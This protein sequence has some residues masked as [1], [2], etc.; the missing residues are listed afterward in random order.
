MADKRPFPPEEFSLSPPTKRPKKKVACQR[1]HSQ[2]IKCTGEQPCAKCVQS[3]VGNDCQYQARDRKITVSQSYI[4]Q[5][6]AENERLRDRPGTPT[7]DAPSDIEP[8]RVEDHAD[9]DQSRRNP[10]IGDQAWFQSYDPVAPPIYVGEAACTAFATR[11]RRFL[12]GNTTAAHIPRTQYMSE[13][14]LSALSNLDVPWPSFTHASLLLKVAFHQA[15]RVYHMMCRK[16][17]FDTLKETYETQNF[18][19][20]VNK[21]KFFTLFALGEV[22]S[23]RSNSSTGQVPGVNY[24][25]KSLAL[26]QILPER[27]TITHIEN[28]LLLSLFSYSL[29]R[30]HHA[31]LLIGNAMRHALVIGMNHNLGPSQVLDPVERE[32]RVRIWWTIYI[33]DRMWGSKMGIPNS[34]LDEDIHVDMPTT[35]SPKES[36]DDQFSDTDYAT[37]SVKLARIAGEAIVKIYSRKTYKETFLQRVQ[38]L[39][40]SLK[41]W[42]ETLPEH[43]RLKSE[44]S[45]RIN[46]KYIVSLHLSFNQIIILT[47]RP[48][49]LRVVTQMSKQATE[50]SGSRDGVS[51]AALTLAEACIH[52]AKHSHSLIIHQWTSGSLPIFGYFSVQYLF[53]AAM[54]MLMSS[55]I[56]T[57]NAMSDMEAFETAAQVLQCMSGDGNLAASEFSRNLDEIKL[58]LEIYK[59]RRDDTNTDETRVG[60]PDS[61]FSIAAENGDISTNFASGT[62]ASMRNAPGAFTTEMAFLEPT[63]QS[64]LAQSDFDLG[65]LNPAELSGDASSSLYFWNTPQWTE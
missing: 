17:T 31:F 55:L 14:T 3:G 16:S 60:L 37:A 38:Q 53:S 65:L 28:L 44:D 59:G 39:L 9:P 32:H 19:S 30:R 50:R 56:S 63:M 27:P 61:T 64:F 43:L 35:I 25:S 6:L 21:C 45:G 42:V 1:C 15:G 2:K 62:S 36:H 57:E 58:S 51:Q 4:D 18:D 8:R 47:T 33:F 52:A 11:L 22:Y 41:S 26:I 24:Y 12:T 7:R 48:M 10:I 29:N 46:P 34:I 20:P 23:I 40:K 5:L 49:L 54:V 13:A